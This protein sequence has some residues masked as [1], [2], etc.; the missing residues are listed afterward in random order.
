MKKEIMDSVKSKLLKRTFACTEVIVKVLANIRE[1]KNWFFWKRN[2]TIHKFLEL[3]WFF[4]VSKLAKKRDFKNAWK[5]KH[6]KHCFKYLLREH[7]LAVA[8]NICSSDLPCLKLQVLAAQCPH[9]SALL[10]PDCWVTHLYEGNSNYQLIIPNSLCWQNCWL[11]WT[12][13]LTLGAA[14]RAL[15]TPESFLSVT[16]CD[17]LTGIWVSLWTEGGWKTGEGG[18]IDMK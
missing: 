7:I 9:P 10:R 15:W 2:I 8:L 18:R 6:F 12:R 14:L 13:S 11:W 17:I 16:F 5:R 4:L 1:T 3:P